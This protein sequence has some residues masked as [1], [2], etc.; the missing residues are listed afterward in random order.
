[1]CETGGLPVPA[2]RQQPCASNAARE[3]PPL[4][5]QESVG[6]FSVLPASAFPDD[7][8][9]TSVPRG[10]KPGK[11]QRMRTAAD[12]SLAISRFVQV[13]TMLGAQSTLGVQPAG[14]VVRDVHISRLLSGF[15]RPRLF[16]ATYQPFRLCVNGGG[17]GVLHA[18]TQ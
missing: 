10:D 3:G 9:R 6:G 15:L 5:S 1:M 12:C 2:F 18:A 7:T 4:A 11:F 16:C 8:I 17:F 14:S 13:L